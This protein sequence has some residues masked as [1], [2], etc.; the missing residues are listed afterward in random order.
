MSEHWVTFEHAQELIWL[1]RSEIYRRVRR[2]WVNPAK[3]AT[4]GIDHNPIEIAV[5]S[6]PPFAQ[7][8]Y[9][10]GRQYAPLWSLLDS[11]V[12]G[13]SSADLSGKPV[14]PYV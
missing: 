8:L 12:P 1:S 10:M 13:M 3:L 6:L 7:Q 9:W 5:S 4:R 11:D 14:R 2:A